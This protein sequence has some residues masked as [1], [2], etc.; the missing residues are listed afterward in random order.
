M[1][2]HTRIAAALLALLLLGC[3]CTAA[4]AATIGEQNALRKAESYLRLTAFSYSG[5]IKQLEYSGFTHS[6][7]VYAANNCGADWYDNALR[8][9]KSYLELTSFS[10]SGLIGQLEYSGFTHAQAVY[11]ANICFNRSNAATAKPQITAA[12]NPLATPTPPS[13]ATS[14]STPVVG[15]SFFNTPFGDFSRY[16]YEELLELQAALNKA[17]WAS[18]GWQNVSVPAGVY[19][20]GEDIPAGHWTISEKNDAY[21]RV[22]GEMNNGELSNLLYDTDLNEPVNLKLYD[23]NYIEIRYFSVNFAPYVSGLGFTFN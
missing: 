3:I 15:F 5:L 22:Y 19:V 14:T 9:A 1:K 7:A 21:F 6:E 12:L 20:V 11:A 8:K 18:D 10:Y 2:H 16:S 17:L 13:I 4:S 23:G